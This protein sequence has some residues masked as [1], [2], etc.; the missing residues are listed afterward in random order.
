MCVLILG[1]FGRFGVAVTIVEGESERKAIQVMATELLVDIQV[2]LLCLFKRLCISSNRHEDMRA[3]FMSACSASLRAGVSCVL[4]QA[5]RYAYRAAGGHSGRMYCLF[6]S[7]NAPRRMTS[8][9]QKEK[10]ETNNA[11]S[12]SPASFRVLQ[13][14]CFECP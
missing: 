12:A 10:K 13:S 14:V 9:R 7:T 11:D 1:R 5:V 4:K 2:S 6:A 8:T 3:A